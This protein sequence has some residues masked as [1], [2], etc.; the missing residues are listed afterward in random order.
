MIQNSDF[1]EGH[2]QFIEYAKFVNRTYRHKGAVGKLAVTP[3]LVA[4]IANID[5]KILD[6]G[7]GTQ[8]MHA[9][10]LRAMGY[11]VDAYEIGF[12]WRYGVHVHKPE[13]G[14]YRWVYLSNVLNVQPDPEKFEMVVRRAAE[15][16]SEDGVMVA[17]YPKSPRHCNLDG[18]N[19]HEALRKSFINI[20]ATLVRG[21]PIFYCWNVV[22]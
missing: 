14:A 21:T 12:N 4:K 18:K 8:A 19:M 13:P 10:M 5:D 6:F 16:L 15:F 1:P 3:R 11:N 2:I 7:A 17:N 22:K 20:T 9:H